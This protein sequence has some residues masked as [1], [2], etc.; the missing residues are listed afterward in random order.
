MSL[1]SNRIGVMSQKLKTNRAGSILGTIL[2]NNFQTKI[3][4]RSVAGSVTKFGDI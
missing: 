4:R 3:E 2:L 1:D